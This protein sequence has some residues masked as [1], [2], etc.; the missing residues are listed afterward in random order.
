MRT[1]TGLAKAD[2]KKAL[3]A[4]YPTRP[5]K[6]TK[7]S[8]LIQQLMA[9]V[10]IVD[11]VVTTSFANLLTLGSGTLG[12]Y[13]VN[14]YFDIDANSILITQENTIPDILTNTNYRLFVY[15][16]N[17]SKN[18]GVSSISSTPLTSNNGLSIPLPSGWTNTDDFAVYCGYTN[19]LSGNSSLGY[20]TTLA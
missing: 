6:Q 17:I 13:F 14:N 20:S 2:S 19:I 8:R 7:F 18:A 16:F 11:G 10:T 1:V 4:L 5:S 9:A 12:N 3:D 15:V